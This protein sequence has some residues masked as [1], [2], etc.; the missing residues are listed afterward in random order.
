[1]A[2][3][4]GVRATCEAL[5][6]EGW[7]DLLLG[8]TDGGFDMLATSLAEELVTPLATID[9]TVP[10][11]EDFAPAGGQAIQPGAPAQSLL[12]HALASP[13]VQ[14]VGGMSL[15]AFP[16]PAQIEAV[17]NYVYGAAPPTL[18]TLIGGG[19]TAGVAVFAL[20][21][22]PGRR[23]PHRRHAD[24]CCSRTG[25]CR[26]G[27]TAPSYDARSRQWEALDAD[28]PFAFRVLPV[29]YAPFIAV[30]RPGERGVLPDRFVAGDDSRSFWVPVH[31]LFDGGEC[32]QGLTLELDWTVGHINE[33]L[34]RFHLFL[35][36][37]G[38]DTGWSGN[39]LDGP[40]FSFAEGIAE[41]STTLD[42]GSGIVMP[43]VH[44]HLVEGAVL[45]GRPLALTVP[46][47]LEAARSHSHVLARYFSGLEIAPEG[48][49][50]IASDDQTLTPAGRSH[51]APEIV[52][53]RHQLLPDGTEVNLN[54]S[55]HVW[56]IVAAGGYQA[57]HYLDF[58][59][60]GWVGVTCAAL[61]RQ[62]AITRSAY[63]IVSGPDFFPYCDQLPLMEWTAT[64]PEEI[65]LGLWAVLPRALSDTRR[66]PNQT[67]AGSGF[68]PPA[69]PG[70]TDTTVT[71]IVCQLEPQDSTPQTW[72]DTG[73]LLQSSLP[74]G[75]SGVFDPGWDITTDSITEQDDSDL[76][77]VAYGLGTPFVEDMKICA[78]LATYW[79]AAAPDAARTFQPDKYWPTIS[80]LTDEEIGIVGDMAWDGVKGPV[81][82]GV[83][84]SS[85]VEYTDIDYSDYVDQA[86]AGKLTAAL[87]S[88]IDVGEYTRRVLA[89]AWTYWALGLRLPPPTGPDGKPMS[90]FQRVQT[91]LLAKAEWNV[92]SFRVV[93]LDDP[94]LETALAATGT[95]LQGGNVYG[96]T[97][98]RHGADNDG[99]TF[100]LRH[101]E[102]LEEADFYTDLATMLITRGGAAWQAT[103]IPTS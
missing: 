47:G 56:D 19:D 31:K 72:P 27:T 38:Y 68:A 26:V 70:T 87:T 23:T 65:R 8:V 36:A 75:A 17:E 33:K 89:M 6:Q 50:P 64:L 62:I 55:P 45:G 66:A 43:T 28:D 92:L 42:H 84:P 80:P 74:D 29:R 15:G 32:I 79:P 77:L 95:T 52:N 81:R 103:A 44:E 18:E 16:T 40:P 102:I 37:Q 35:E 10:G 90:F 67:L 14:S 85:V 5:A 78:A 96:G 54:D 20:E 94:G 41:L 24:L 63:S 71:A 59:G 61:E 76:F 98:F 57:R 25:I 4:D 91:F 49:L 9:R 1:M 34:R 69:G 21:Y 22:R 60:D 100:T 58:T 12:Y 30:L 11:F 53:A 86:L 13:L 82:V 73:A 101:V 46:K 7:R 99:P 88:R 3:I 83:G 2:L 39:V 97:V 51:H 48:P 93:P